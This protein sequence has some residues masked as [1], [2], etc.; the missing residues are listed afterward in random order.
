[1]AGMKPDN[2]NEAEM[3]STYIKNVTMAAKKFQPVCAHISL[4]LRNITILLHLLVYY[5]RYHI[6]VM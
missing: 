5:K 3:E 1:M 2:C 4:S 6:N